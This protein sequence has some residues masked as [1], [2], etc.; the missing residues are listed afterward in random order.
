[1]RKKGLIIG[2][3]AICYSKLPSNNGVE[4]KIMY[5]HK[6]GSYYWYQTVNTNRPIGNN[7]NYFIDPPGSRWSE[8][9]I[10]KYL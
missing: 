1:M 8:I 3:F 4:L 10:L 5:Y 9:Q 6:R 7:G 2:K